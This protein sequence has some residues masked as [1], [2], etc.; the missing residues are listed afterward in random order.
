[1]HPTMIAFSVLWVK[2]DDSSD[3]EDEYKPVMPNCNHN[4]IRLKTIAEI[5]NQTYGNPIGVQNSHEASF[6]D[7]MQAFAIHCDKVRYI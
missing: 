2:E 4:T 7:D 6:G 3:D 1:M 5:A